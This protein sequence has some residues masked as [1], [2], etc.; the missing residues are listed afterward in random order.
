MAQNFRFV[1][2][3]KK[4]IPLYVVESYTSVIISMDQTLLNCLKLWKIMLFRN[5]HWLPFCVTIVHWASGWATLLMGA[6]TSTLNLIKVRQ[7]LWSHPR[8]KGQKNMKGLGIKLKTGSFQEYSSK[9]KNSEEM[10]VDLLDYNGKQPQIWVGS[11]WAQM[12][13][14]V[15][16]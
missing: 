9:Q 11:L 8:T 2:Q 4:I 7:L 14:R 16:S 13:T 1:Q 10:G 6:A 15:I 12:S 5:V 3:T